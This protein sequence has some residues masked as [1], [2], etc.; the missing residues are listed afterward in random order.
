MAKFQSS[1]LRSP[2]SSGGEARRTVEEVAHR[3][4]PGMDALVREADAAVRQRQERVASIRD[5]DLRERVGSVP[6]V[7]SESW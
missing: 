3:L 4:Q 1:S 5:P 7:R 6:G 2:Q